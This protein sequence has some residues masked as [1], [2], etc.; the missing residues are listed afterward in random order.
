LPSICA[1]VRFC[2]FS[3]T[4]RYCSQR[5]SQIENSRVIDSSS[6][7]GSAPS[8]PEPNDTSGGRASGP[9]PH[10][11]PRRICWS[12]PGAASNAEQRCEVHR[13][14]RRHA[15][16]LEDHRR[17]VVLE[18][19]VAP[20]LDLPSPSRRACP[21]CDQE[22]RA[23]ARRRQ[24]RQLRLPAGE[25]QEQEKQTDEGHFVDDSRRRRASARPGRTGAA[26]PR[27]RNFGAF[28]RIFGRRNLL[29]SALEKPSANAGGLFL[30][31]RPQL[32][33]KKDSPPAPFG[34]PV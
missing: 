26:S 27:F 5:T 34:F 18:N 19:R 23:R 11:N 12:R 22:G 28:I 30:L 1:E 29:I 2:G 6:I 17:R 8:G 4:L 20:Y 9:I 24:P 15:A 25:W 14:V 31:V 3:E 13:T 16:L 21:D 7:L 33:S 32:R 10:S